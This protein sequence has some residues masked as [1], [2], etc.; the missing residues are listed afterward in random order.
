MKIYLVGGALRDEL[1]DLI[2]T[3]RDYVVVGATEQDM[4]DRGFR[5]MDVV[6][7]VF[8]HPQTGEEYALARRETKTGPGYKGFS[9]DAGPDVTLEDDLLRRDLTINALARDEFGR[10]IDL[11]YGRD[12]LESGVMRHITPAFIE[13]P[14]R[15]LRT[16]RFSAKLGRWG[17]RVAHDTF[18]LMREMA[19]LDEF[20]TVFPERFREEMRKALKVE[21]PWRFFETLQRCGALQRLL[22]PLSE[23]MGDY[24]SHAVM[25]VS[26]PVSVLRRIAAAT[27]DPSVRFAALM[28]VALGDT[29]KDS[30]AY[31]GLSLDAAAQDM[32]ER[33]LA[34]PGEVM[35]TADADM[36]MEFLERLRLL[37]HPDRLAQMRM[38][39]NAL[40]PQHAGMAIHRS[41]AAL[42]AAHRIDAHA[43][44]TSGLTG[45]ALG[46]ALR[47]E[48]LLA[49]QQAVQ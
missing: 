41:Q 20:S 7:P 32:L 15:L 29:H 25:P 21:Q 16:A 42:D 10:I 36:M 23:A 13:D 24:P 40:D 34:W 49:V 46:K 19:S 11:F 39:W 18:E 43:L 2:V 48:R 9:V 28:A 26:D 44:S 35:A 14:V 30:K 5:R 22:P 6:F 33:A 45:P 17:F 47:A 12:D 4:L 3:E 38:L 31:L 27:P 37:H 1:L 8:L